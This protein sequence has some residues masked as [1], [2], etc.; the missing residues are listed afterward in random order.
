ME[1]VKRINAVIVHSNQR[2]GLAQH[3]LYAMD[4]NYKNQNCYN[5]GGFGHLA[6]NY[7]N[8]GIGYRIGKGKRLEYRERRENRQDRNLNGEENPIVL[9]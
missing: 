9:D 8:R 6:R 2:A 4:M 7:R 5:Y 1:G 3:N